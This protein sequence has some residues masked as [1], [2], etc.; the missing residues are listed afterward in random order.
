MNRVAV[1]IATFGG[2]GFFPWGPGTAGSVASFIL[3]F[4]LTYLT[5]LAQLGIWVFIFFLGWWATYQTCEQWQVQD[6]SR[7]VIDEVIG[8]GIATWQIQPTLSMWFIAFILFRIFDI[9]KPPPIRFLDRKSKTQTS[10]YKG[11]FLVIFDDIVAGVYAWLLIELIQ[12]G[13]T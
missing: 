4:F 8:M 1:S 7:I 11:A 5:P 9:A 10:P 3:I 13:W 2:V 6:D 12:K